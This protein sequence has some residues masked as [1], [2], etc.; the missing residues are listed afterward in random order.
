M[1]RPCDIC[2]A[3]QCPRHRSGRGIIRPD[4]CLGCLN[5]VQT[6]YAQKCT[7]P[8]RTEPSRRIVAVET[9]D[10]NPDAETL[11]AIYPDYRPAYR[12][13]VIYADRTR[14]EVDRERFLD[15]LVAKCSMEKNTPP[16]VVMRARFEEVYPPNDA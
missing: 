16:A 13:W 12:F 1:P 15:A 6:P 4:R 2:K 14:E 9:L 11:A 10:T 3:K 7:C 5:L 8:G